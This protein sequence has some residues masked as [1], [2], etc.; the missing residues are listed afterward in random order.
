MK[1]KIK[2]ELMKLYDQQKKISKA[3]TNPL[4]KKLFQG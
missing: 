3:V 1:K 2:E 4:L